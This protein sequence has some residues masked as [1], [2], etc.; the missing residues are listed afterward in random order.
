[1]NRCYDMAMSNHD[2]D[3][4][5]IGSGFGGSVSALRL[6]QKGYRVAVIEAGKR[7]ADTDF[8]KTNWNLR[9]FLWLPQALCYGIQRITLLK[10]VM[11]LS[12]AGVGGG[13]LVYANTLYVPPESFF[14]HPTLQAMGGNS[15]I[16]PYY[17][18]AQR[19]LG[20][21]PNP[22]LW[23]IDELMRETAREFGAADS[24]KPTPVGVY[25]GEANQ[26]VADPYFFG[27]G[28]ERTGCNDC[29]G[30]MVGCRFGAKNTLVKNYLYLAEKLGATI[31]PESQVT[32]VLPLSQDGAEG[33]TIKMRSTTQKLKRTRILRSQGV[34]FSAGVLGT[35]GLLLKQREQ[36][37]LPRLSQRLG[38]TV[39]TNSE[40]I[41]GVIA[42]DKS[43]DYSKGIAI[44]SSV[45][46]DADSHIEPVRY[47][48]GSGAMGL[49]ATLLT[50]GGGNQP[51]QLQYLKNIWRQPGDFFKLLLPRD[52]AER[53]IFVLFMQ[54]L[55]NSLQVVRKRS[56]LSLGRKALSTAPEGGS[57]VPSYIPLANEFTRKLA[58]K[59]NAIPGSAINEVLLDIPTTAHILGGCSI[60]A[61][62]E[63]GV[64]DLQNRVFGYQNMLI[65]D[66]SM[67]P[68]NLGVNPSLSIT[69]L[70]ERAMSYLPLKPRQ[71][72]HWL[73]AD[74]EWGIQADLLRSPAEQNTQSMDLE[75]T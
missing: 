39:R 42:R 44:T 55:D 4:I 8:P 32:E 11:I 12:G 19:M 60:G 62:P 49:L 48:K 56:W 72:M 20:V 41:L 57:K 30:C 65:C 43:V 47:S 52:F 27:E 29:G 14:E 24:F 51:R 67:M 40:A 53:S 73:Q 15:G 58:K 34:V 35:L 66:G 36:G 5:I 21:V 64:I 13:S 45:Y 7:F 9:K 54:T 68:A 1:M 10:D 37:S 74:Q 33:Y 70:T 22:R 61:N 2:Y 17:Q 23:P 28:P 71:Q 3:Y 63:Q 26:T 18:I 16:M 38:K 69:A 46:P 50:D 25:F 59:M 31:I 6:T 75:P